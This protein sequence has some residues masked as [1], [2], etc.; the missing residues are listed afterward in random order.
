MLADRYS[1]K[2]IAVGMERGEKFYVAY[3]DDKP[4]GYA[5]VE[6]TGDYYYLHKFYLDVNKHRGG[7]GSQFFNYLLAQID[8]A[9]PIRLQV[10]RQNIKAI[11]FY[12]KVGFVIERADDFDIGG[13]FF[14]NDF[15]M[16][17]QP[18]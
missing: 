10:N 6:L 3:M 12:F 15:V 8:S 16:L 9:R 2:V 18:A 1:E 7:I 5:S 11:N 17:R 14:M 4:V 13:G